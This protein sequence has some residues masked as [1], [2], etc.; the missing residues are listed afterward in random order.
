[1]LKKKKKSVHP[2]DEP[3]ARQK[4]CRA[5]GPVE[6]DESRFDGPGED[7]PEVTVDSESRSEEEAREEEEEESD[8]VVDVSET[9][10]VPK[11]SN[12]L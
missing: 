9:E 6:R 7:E 11:K 10:N 12:G 8:G 4:T 1:V 2:D 5:P 3:L